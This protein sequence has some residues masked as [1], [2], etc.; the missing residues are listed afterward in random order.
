VAC[1]S[2]GTYAFTVRAGYKAVEFDKGK[3]VIAVPSLDKLPGVIDISPARS[4][5]ASLDQQLAAAS[6]PA[7]PKKARKAC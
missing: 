6:K 1:C 2:N 4:A 3:A 5:M 7:T